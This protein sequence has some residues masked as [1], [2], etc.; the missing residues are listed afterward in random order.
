MESENQERRERDMK[1]WGEREKALGVLLFCSYLFRRWVTITIY[2]L[3][4]ALK[5]K[6]TV[7]QFV[8]NLKNV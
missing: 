5:K 4:Y 6:E 7:L 8:S 2:G 3:I 1:K